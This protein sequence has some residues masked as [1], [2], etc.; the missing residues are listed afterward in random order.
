MVKLNSQKVYKHTV[1]QVSIKIMD[2][3]PDYQGVL[4]IK[5]AWLSRCP[6][7]LISRVYIQN[8][9]TVKGI[10]LK[11][12]STIFYK[13]VL[14]VCEQGSNQFTKTTNLF[15]HVYKQRSLMSAGN[16]PAST[17]TLVCNEEPEA[18]LVSTQQDS[19]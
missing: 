8:V 17:T 4:I 19:N 3:C 16:A 1:F 6:D 10:L 18:T 14:N 5:V 7:F 13:G 15:L 11:R 9:C 12:D 2:K